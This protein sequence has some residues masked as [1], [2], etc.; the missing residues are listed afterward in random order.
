MKKRLAFYGFG[1][2]LGMI[3]LL[4]FLNGKRASCNFFPNERVLELLRNKHRTYS[5]DV[6]QIMLDNSIDSVQVDSI[7]VFGD[8]DFSK[9]KVHQEPCRYYWVDG[10][11]HQGATSLYIKNCDTIITIEN[12]Y[13]TK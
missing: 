5:E 13:L 12:I 10:T 1:F 7:L 11:I 2:T 4:F 8:V 3:L 6:L 9:S